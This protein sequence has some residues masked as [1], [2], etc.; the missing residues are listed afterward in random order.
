[1]KTRKQRK[2]QI[3][4]Q[5]F[6]YILSA[7][8]ITMIMIYGY[9]AIS[10]VRGKSNDLCVLKLKNDLG[11]IINSI[12]EDFGTTKL[13]DFRICEDFDTI[14]F[15]ESFES[16]ILPLN[17]HPRIKSELNSNTGNNIFFIGASKG[18][19]F[20]AGKISVEPDVNCLKMKKSRIHLRFEG[21][22][23]HIEISEEK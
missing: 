8:L 13:K 2:S 10:K 3:Y 15:V 12:S 14:C 20:S 11:N 5:I 17:I 6:I 21:K 19:A 9:S 18:E 23:D 16:P 22:G 1:M 4:G 7:V